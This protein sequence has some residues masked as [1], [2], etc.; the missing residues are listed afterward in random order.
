MKIWNAALFLGITLL[1]FYSSRSNAQVKRQY[2]NN[3]NGWFMYVGN[4]K[5]SDKWGLHLE[6]QWRRNEIILNN[7]QLLFRAGVNHYL[8]AQVLLTAGYCYVVT[9]PYGALAAKATFPENRIW[10]QLNLKTAI[11]AMEVINRFRLE[12]RY[13]HT[14]VWKD[15][16][17]IPG[18]AV[19][20][21]RVR[22]MS[23]YSL[24]FKGR[25]IE[26]RS[27]YLSF[28]DELFINFGEN[29]GYNILDQNRAYVALGYKIPKLGRLEL[30]YMNQLIVR[31]DG[32]KIEQNHTFQLGLI[33]TMEFRKKKQ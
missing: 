31:S 2:S 12:Q 9:Y 4:H 14:P 33:S 18:D 13:V 21:N 3:S 17:Y 20:T 11:G 8:S 30:G 7:Q 29:V 24:P 22:W 15:S 5:L 1:V 6:A 28:Y 27:C 25:T 10:E 19:Y 16:E 26:D 32:I 23:R